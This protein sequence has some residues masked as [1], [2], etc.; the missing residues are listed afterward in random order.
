MDPKPNEQQVRTVTRSWREICMRAHGKDWAKP[1]TAYLFGNGR[2]FESTDSRGGG[3][4]E[5]T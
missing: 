4:Y 3:V 5:K 2:A 1:E